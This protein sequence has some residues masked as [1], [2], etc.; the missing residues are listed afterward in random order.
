MESFMDGRYKVLRRL[1]EGAYGEVFLTEHTALGVQRAIKRIRKNH[2][3][4]HTGRNEVDILKGLKFSGLPIVYDVWDDEEFLYIVEEYVQGIT[5]AQYVRDKGRLSEDESLSITLSICRILMY[6]QENGGICHLDLKPENII[7]DNGNAKLLDFGSGITQMTKISGIKRFVIMGTKGYAA[8]ESY[9]GLYADF[10]QDIYSLGIIMIYMLEGKICK[11][12]QLSCNDNLKNIIAKCTCH[13]RGGRFASYGELIRLL[14]ESH[15]KKTSYR[16]TR[17]CVYGS[18]GRVGTTHFCI[19]LAAY[20]KNKKIDAPVYFHGNFPPVYE[21]D[22][23]FSCRGG[24]YMADGISLIPDYNGYAH[25]YKAA[26]VKISDEGVFK[27]I[28]KGDEKLLHILI[29]GHTNEE[30]VAYEKCARAFKKLGYEFITAIN[31]SGGEEWVRIK[32][33]HNMKNVIRI[34]FCPNPYEFK[35]GSSFDEIQRFL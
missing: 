21:G 30:L 4:H 7:I 23:S 27:E 24:V 13:G 31:F 9:C 32:R 2:A 11:L 29:C 5:L 34:P 26:L 22:I 35:G 28:S 16:S 18:E 15:S 1:G 25:A 6:M 12:S 17:I 3:R 19:M 20:L 33:L 14:E 10:R 8:P